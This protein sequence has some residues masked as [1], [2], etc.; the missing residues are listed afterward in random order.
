MGDSQTRLK[1]AGAAHPLIWSAR[2]TKFEHLTGFMRRA[3]VMILVLFLPVVN[4]YVAPISPPAA[5]QIE[6]EFILE[7]PSG[8]WTH[9]LWKDLQDQ[10][11]T[12]LRV[13]SPTQL[14]V[15]G[16][17]P[18]APE[19]F[20][21]DDAPPAAWKSGLN[22]AGPVHGELVRIVLEPR[23]PNAVFEGLR[24][25]FALMGIGL[26]GQH[27]SSPLA[28]A[29]IVEWPIELDLAK[30]LLLDGL[31]W[32]EPVLETQG[33]NVQAASLMQHGAMSGHP[34]WN[35]GINGTGVV[36]G[37][38]DSGLDADHACFRNATSAQAL[39]SE[40]VNGTDLVGPAGEEHRKVLVLN[41]TIDDGDT[42]GHSDYRHGTHVA[43]SLAC[44]NVDDERLGLY[45]S[46]GSS[47]SHGSLLV[48]Q[49]IVSSDG[50][51]PPDVDQLL[52][53][54]GLAG[55][56]I[57]SNSWGDDTTAYTART[58]DFDAWALA[59]PWSLAFIAPGNTGGSL[60]EPANGRNVAAIGASMKSED[61]A[62]W[63]ASSSGPTEAGTTGIFALA[64]GSSVQSARADNMDDSYNGDLRTSTGTSMATP[65]AAGVA[66]LIQQLV[67]LGWVSGQEVR[68]N[69]SM[70]T[71]IPA[72]SDASMADS[73]IDVG[74][75][76]TPS[77]PM[78]R[79]LLALSTTPLP[80][81]ARDDGQGGYDLQNPH[82]GFGQLNLS[83]LLDFE[84]LIEELEGGH[85]SPANDVWIHD[86]YRLLDQSPQEWL[87]TRQGV[88]DPLEN[89]IAQPWNGSGAAGPFLRTGEVWTQ[90]FT[91]MENADLEVR[92]AH[93]A[94]PEPS[95]VNDL[96]LVARL[97]DGRVVSSAST[98]HD[99]Y[100]TLFYSG[101]DLDNTTHFPSANETTLGLRI[102]QTELAE[103]DWIEVEVRARFVAPGGLSDGVGLDG[104]RTGFAL[105]V[106][107]VERDGLDWLDGDGDSVPNAEDICPNEN[108]FGWD[109][110]NDGCLDDTDGDDVVD[111]LDQCPL[112]DASL[113]DNDSDGCI[114]DT[115][116]DGVQDD[117]DMCVTQVPDPLWPVGTNGC[118]PV[119]QAPAITITQSP[120]N[121]T[122][123]SGNI[124]VRWS[125]LDEDGDAFQTGAQITVLSQPLNESGYA[126]ANCEMDANTSATFEC[127]WDSMISLPVWN[128]EESW[129]RIDVFVESRNASPEG[130]TNRIV[131]QSSDLFKAH[132]DDP[133]DAL[134]DGD[135][136]ARSQGAA[137]QLRAV[138][139]G[140]ATLVF[141]GLFA[142]R[143]GVKNL[144]QSE[145]YGAVDPFIKTGSDAL[146]D[147][148]SEN[149]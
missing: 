112:V 96:L 34:A 82:D 47:L 36:V 138:L 103:I 19:A 25:D 39:G 49:D 99:G 101:T 113:Y 44:F 142:Y 74:Q 83:V 88:D 118:R 144:S 12:P 116:E 97:S 147:L 93:A 24:E 18:S 67:E 75:G 27:Q 91:P 22:G 6:G 140:A 65:G 111:S 124:T 122:L 53:E 129:L 17:E 127:K 20:I 141:V 64:V 70:D 137:S 149:E 81:A 16:H 114:D 54:S 30:V 132:Y 90:R 4:A 21:V 92:M 37:A 50:W 109:T 35:L 31:L 60:L 78:L 32:I 86:S 115:D 13:V 107:G 40:G 8:V 58:A 84:A 98:D 77:G 135:D 3:L 28:P 131:I 69:V 63:T 126:I 62:R 134:S 2:L 51:V 73:T 57:H 106:Q 10:G 11:L 95:A 46:N 128:I 136:V 110:D 117:L 76:F 79:A 9:D 123:W 119:D 55:G 66:S 26:A 33:R 56:V 120:G 146:F 104:S 7:H 121:G 143:I 145:R 68:S 42:A 105:A 45:P 87:T 38:A 52:V 23:L 125:V 148:Q 108:A 102:D 80:P 29:Y 61:T 94:S 100:S 59:M 133:S 130:N 43:G 41:T 71:M 139:W 48:F 72:W 85:A 14:L 1:R 89:L 15:W 5:A